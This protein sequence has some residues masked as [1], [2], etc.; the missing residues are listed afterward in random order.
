MELNFVASRD[1]TAVLPLIVLFV[2]SL[3][4]MGMKAFRGGLEVKPMT[5]FVWGMLGIVGASGTSFGVTSTLLK[6]SDK[7]S[8]G[9][10][11]NML[12]VDG[13]GLWVSYL[14]FLLGAVALMIGYDH[15]ATKGRHFSEH[16]FLLLNSMIGMVLVA[17]SNDLLMTFIAIEFMS[18]ALYLLIAISNEKLL[19][20]EAAFKYFVLGSFASAFM[21]FGVSFVYGTVG[22]TQ[23]PEITSAALELMTASK[24]FMVGFLLVVIGFAFKV[25]LFPFHS[26]TPDVYQGSPTSVT[27]L[28]STAVKAAS[29]IAFLRL[30]AGSNL[31][32]LED[33]DLLNIMQWLAIFT[34]TIGN[35]AALIQTN[36]KRMLAYSSI[37]H[38]GYLMIGL[39][40]A[41]FGSNFDSGATGLLF[42][43][44]S[45]ALMTMGT[46][47]LVAL[48]EKN[49]DSALHVDQLKGLAKKSPL[50]AWAFFIL[51]LS[52]AGVPPTLGFFG[53]FYLFSSAVEQG[54]V[55][56][57][58][59]GL[60]NS[61][62]SVY[63]YL[64]PVVNM[65]MSD[66]QD[67][68]RVL[69]APLT[70]ATLVIAAIFIVI[71]GLASGP[72]LRVV[73]QAVMVGG[74]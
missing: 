37:A 17:W 70:Q 36:V 46:F 73:Q 5:T 35:V 56:L 53:K 65:F 57:V 64:R 1:L 6:L 8:L 18:L 49:L 52:L 27:T 33:K 4:P 11:S 13:L 20:K 10:F 74:L 60:I 44:F 12:V 54:F 32:R 42:Y 16:L 59:W 50:M 45:Y 34:M 38:S 48:F 67:Q 43:L 3:I 66:S 29:F 47:A 51:M 68:E 63:Y 21:L 24:L 69:P 61:V 26:W 62:I 72:L 31:F 30:F 41:G 55:W 7:R 39:I 58:F 25:S 19:S 71:L 22:S 14:I 23:L 40:A 9:V 15:I 28:M 2:A